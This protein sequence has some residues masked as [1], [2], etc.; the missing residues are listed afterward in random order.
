LHVI[1]SFQGINYITKCKNL[2][3][4]QTHQTYFMLLHTNQTEKHEIKITPCNQEFVVSTIKLN[5]NVIN[6][7]C[8]VKHA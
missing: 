8:N 7:E 5:K 4:N 1:S 3:V 6:K 2:S